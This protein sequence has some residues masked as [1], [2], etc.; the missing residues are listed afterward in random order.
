MN[1]PNVHT[2]MRWSLLLPAALSLLVCSCSNLKY[3]PANEQLYVGGKVNFDPKVKDQKDLTEELEGL[4][5]PKPNSKVLGL[6]YKLWLY[7]ISKPPKGKGLNYLLHEKWG[8]PPVLARTLD[9]DKN[10]DIL[11][12]R[13]QNRGFFQG[14]VDADSSG[15]NRKVTAVYTADAGHRYTIREVRFPQED[16]PLD[17]LI[18][19]TAK[20]TLLKPGDYY[21][22][23]RIKDERERID[24]ALKEQ[25]YFYFSP[26]NLIMRVDSSLGGV[27]DINVRVKDDAPEK[28]L[29]PYAIRNININTNYSLSGN[30]RRR[31]GEEY[32]Y[33][34]FSILDTRHQFRPIIFKRS[35]FFKHGG[36]YTRRM[37]NLTLN[38]LV[39]L[40]V[41]KFVK[42]EFT[43]VLQNPKDSLAREKARDTA[44][45]ERVDFSERPQATDS[46]GRGLM[47]A[48]FYLTPDKKK[49][50]RFQV[51]GYSKSNNFVGS[52][53]S[54]SARNRNWL[55]GAELLEVKLAGGF[56]T[57]VGGKQVTGSSNS[58]SLS[59]EVNLYIPR[60][61]TPFK[62]INGSTIFV[63]KTIL[64]VGY[65]LLKRTGF[66]N[67]N[68]FRF[69]GGYNW[70]ENEAK[71]HTLNV[72]S[73]NYVLPSH[74]TDTF[75]HRLDLDPVLRQSFEKQFI[76]GTNYNYV[77][78]DQLIR[79]SRF[80]TY[81]NGNVDV[82]GNLLGAVMG[83]HDFEH[84]AT[85]G[86]IPFSQ[87]VR[88]SAD[89]RNYWKLNK[90]VRWVN[91]LFIGYGYAYGNSRS[92]PFV[93]QFYIGGSNSIRAFRARA[94]GPGTYY[95][96]ENNLF[97]NEAGDIKLEMN[98]ELRAKL[99]GL[100]NGAVFVD[101]GNIWL[102]RATPERPGGEFHF[103]KALSQLAVGTGVGLR[104]DFSILLLR[105]D[106]AFPLRKPYLPEG[107]RWV[108]DQI[109]FGDAG[110]R[111]E[112]LVLNIAIGYPF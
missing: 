103:S 52:E 57:Q 53:V 27:V 72:V 19:G 28:G 10:R 18:R 32:T 48:N 58:Y 61:I 93:K 23:D 39:N 38:R 71:E 77:Y 33:G 6:R 82:A 63:P 108:L 75:Q 94:L 87:Y 101:A 47:D 84:P 70:K 42:L 7:N 22:L 68:S 5:R 73:V 29:R 17:S 99:F 109:N 67:L 112:N 16:D 44:G 49:S 105:L 41:F 30:Q 65:E 45:I 64:N 11:V 2:K 66:Y 97:A 96:R 55:K 98:T 14:A 8:E 86:N 106:L 56:E 15:K 89:V 104:F 111:K 80:N 31:R 74:I 13:L 107:R 35:V 50:L 90:N 4:L 83:K 9:L 79:E 26:D 76:I 91:R 43:D 12:N 51:S 20:S 36:L 102:Q 78:N 60:F 24:A 46:L 100:V 40:N 3:L 21:D 110:W 62:G 25:G 37:H 81:F 69:Q 88:L 85:I 1:N 95:T 59:P 92:L 34:D 54:I